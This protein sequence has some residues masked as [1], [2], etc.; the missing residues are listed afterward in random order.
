[1]IGTPYYIAPEILKGKGCQKSDVWSVG[2]ISYVLVSGN[3]PF[4]GETELEILKKVKAGYI[5]FMNP[6]F[7][8]ISSLCKDFLSFI[9][10]PDPKER[11]SAQQVLDHPFMKR[12]HD[13]SKATVINDSAM[14]A[15]NNLA[16]FQA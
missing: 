6:V 10:N 2:V 4:N 3:P 15:L 13:A 11:P 14:Q 8:G 7:E 16:N 1:M 5:S 9:L 12:T